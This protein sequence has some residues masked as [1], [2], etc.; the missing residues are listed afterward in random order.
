[1]IDTDRLRALANAA[2]PGPWEDSGGD[3]WSDTHGFLSRH[4]LGDAD[5]TFI[6]AMRNALPALLDALEIA[7]AI[8]GDLR[9]KWEE[10]YE[11]GIRNADH[12]LRLALDI[13]DGR[14]QPTDRIGDLHAAMTSILKGE[15]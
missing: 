1:M 2:T 12:R 5:A 10:G 11:A 7:E 4:G 8:R 6:A 3:I 14:F 13:L 15:L 9:Q